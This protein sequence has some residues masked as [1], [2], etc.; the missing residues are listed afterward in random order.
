MS[1]NFK[2]IQDFLLEEE[3]RSHHSEVWRLRTPVTIRVRG[4]ITTAAEARM[5]NPA[6]TCGLTRTAMAR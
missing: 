5:R 1:L 4:C 2:G 3:K 6:S